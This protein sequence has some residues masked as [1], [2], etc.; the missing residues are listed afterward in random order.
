MFMHYN[1]SIR[2]FIILSVAIISFYQCKNVS[3]TK[4]KKE[5]GTNLIS[6][7]QSIKQKIPLEQKVKDIFDKN[8]DYTAASFDYPVGK[9]SAKGYYNAQAFGKNL[10]LGDDWNALTGGNSDLGDPIYSIAH[11]YV[12][13]A[14]D[15]SGG[16]GN[17]IRIWHR[18]K[19]G[20]IIESFYAH[21]L[22]MHV[23]EGDFV[24]KG[25]KIATIGNV[26]GTYY[27][28]LHF[29][30]RD[31]IN[32]PVGPGY[33]DNTTGYLDPTKFIKENR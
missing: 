13:T 14:K 2:A 4:A 21:C 15:Y 7:Q 8:P 10:H 27:A 12:N 30:I 1:L 24:K 3:T 22:E 26:N 19:D 16:W 5:S 18:K 33:S 25:D 9:P 28:H 11:G 23:K 32:L 29:E 20:K 17:I 31:N 6:K